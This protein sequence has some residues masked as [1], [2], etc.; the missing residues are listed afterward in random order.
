MR[1]NIIGLIVIG[2]LYILF[3][4]NKKA[5]K[6]VD[7]EVIYIKSYFEDLYTKR[8]FLSINELISKEKIVF[9]RIQT[10]EKE[11]EECEIQHRTILSDLKAASK[12]AE[13]MAEKNKNFFSSE[14]KL[15]LT[16]AILLSE[17]NQ[18]EGEV[19][20]KKENA[21]FSSLTKSEKVNI[22]ENKREEKKNHLG[23]KN[24]FFYFK[25]LFSLK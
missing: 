23:K 18:K 25:K 14:E 3:I 21:D 9:E 2:F 6:D 17:T 7:D 4:K 24:L 10:L 8:L 22:V 13:E 19:S 5:S 12:L 16:K 20:S 1:K 15:F 11:L